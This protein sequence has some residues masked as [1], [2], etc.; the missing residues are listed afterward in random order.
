MIRNK[1]SE[2]DA[3][4]TADWHLREDLPVARTD[5]FLAAQIAKIQYI[6]RLQKKH[7]CPIY[8]SGDLFN[9]WKPS[10]FLIS[11]ALRYLPDE[12]YTIYGNHDLPQHNLEL[13]DK[14]GLNTLKEAGKI[15]VL[16]GTHWEK[17][18]TEEDYIY[19]KDRKLLI[20]H[21]MTWKGVL[22]WPDCPALSAVR[23]LKK[24][25]DV[26]VILTGHNHKT[27]TAEYKERLLVNPGSITRQEAGQID[28]EPCVFLYSAQTNMVK[29][30]TI[31]YEISVI[32]R[33]HLDKEKERDDRIHAFISRINSE[34]WSDEVS[35]EE[36][37]ERMMQASGV[38]SSVVSI[39]RKAVYA[40][41]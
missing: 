32:S 4:F 38:R 16:H 3:I 7:K 12:F 33:D 1:K 10:P 34:K 20:W 31:P 2:V 6:G 36:N 30:H 39:V 19:I 37:L 35:F 41:F 27:F 22:P 23:F 13:A 40:D 15:Q 18:P 24:Y 29:K 21:V 9:H 14:S 26:D 17:E 8:H 5:D 11:L 28:H 25:R